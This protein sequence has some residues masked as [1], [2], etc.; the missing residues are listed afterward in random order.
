M[1]A[2]L[3]QLWSIYREEESY[4]IKDAVWTILT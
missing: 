2:D 3:L 4:T 1:L